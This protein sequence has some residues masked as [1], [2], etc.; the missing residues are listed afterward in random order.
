MLFTI[1]TL[2]C[3]NREVL[4]NVLREVLHNTDWNSLA[5]TLSIDRPIEWMIYAQGCSPEFL[6]RIRECFHNSPIFLRLI[7]NPLNEGY[8]R[9]M[10]NVW[11]NVCDN[12]YV[13]FLEDDWRLAS[14]VPANWL[15]TCLQLVKERSEI[16][17]IFLRKYLSDYEKWQ[18]GWT[19]HIPYLC[20]EGRL[21]FNYE[22]TMCSTQP[23]E[24]SGLVF[25][26][27]PQFMYS[28]N[29]CIYK[30]ESFR[31]CGVFPMH[32]MND[33]H[34]VQGQWDDSSKVVS[35]EFGNQWGCAEALSM[36]KTQD[37]YTLYLKDGVFYHNQV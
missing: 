1:A 20:F 11:K 28:A 10:N 6:D 26:Q 30:V 9:G 34:E 36:E 12:D 32:E 16:D 2:T 7:V 5:L 35:G 37:L 31:R 18:Y 21:R 13:L 24:Y 14:D 27:I 17:I 23:F 15:S 25:Q 33:K 4:F 29:P 3:N 8:S 22:A 19:R